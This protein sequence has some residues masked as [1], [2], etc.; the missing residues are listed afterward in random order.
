MLV[1][2]RLKSLVRR[3]VRGTTRRYRTA[4]TAPAI[5]HV[6]TDATWVFYWDSY[7]IT[8]ALKRRG[9]AAHMTQSPWT[10]KD[11]IIHFED[12]YVYLD[13]PFRS[14]DRSNRVILTWY[15]G[16]PAHANAEVWRLLGLLHEA[17]PYLD[18]VLVSCNIARAALIEQ[19]IPPEKLVQIPLGVDLERFV[20]PTPAQRDRIR[21][22]LGLSEDAMVIGS[23]QKDSQGWDDSLEPKLIKGPDMFLRVIEAVA[24]Q[25]PNVWVLLTAPAR[26]YVKA[27]LDRLGVPYVHHI[28]DDYHAIVPYYQAL[29][30]YLITARSEGGPKSL[31][32]SWATGV[33]VVSTRV[34]MPADLIRHGENG[35][36]A[37][38][39]DADALTA[40]TL[41]LLRDDAARARIA[42]QAR[43]DVPQYNWQM[44]AD[45]YVTELYTPLLRRG[46]R[47]RLRRSAG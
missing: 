1:G 19:G 43:Q 27:G 34:G 24:S 22:E 29:D 8:R 4:M 3:I 14:L 9:I 7:Y 18:R 42:A 45:R 39:D 15:H 26:E 30:L 47:R 21:A 33:P 41:A 40:H 11:Q 12:R 31:L 36:L 44:I 25:V 10:L 13:G 2:R 38:I 32:E 5:H 23:F 37:A 28:L 46:I 35:L 16:E 17:V 20:L 6:T